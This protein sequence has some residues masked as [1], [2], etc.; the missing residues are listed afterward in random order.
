MRSVRDRTAYA[1][2]VIAERQRQGLSTQALAEKAGLDRG[3]VEA[4]E[5]RGRSSAG[6]MQAISF[7]LWGRKTDIAAIEEG[8]VPPDDEPELP[9]VPPPP[10]APPKAPEESPAQERASVPQDDE[11]GGILAR[12]AVLERS[13]KSLADKIESVNQRAAD[14]G[15]ALETRIQRLEELLAKALAR[16]QVLESAPR[17]TG[18]FG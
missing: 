3:L 10:P 2:L 6:T 18:W 11:L 7:A 14:R 17:R 1:A 16:I 9:G 8:T 15:L 13:G 4:L 5:S 12:L